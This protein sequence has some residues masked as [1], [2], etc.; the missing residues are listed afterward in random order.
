MN[1]A[2]SSRRALLASAVVA[3]LLGAAWTFLARSGHAPSTAAFYNVVRIAEA[4]SKSIPL[5]LAGLGVALA[6]RAGFWNIGAEGQMLMGALAGAAIGTRGGIFANVFCVLLGGGAAGAAWA[7]I[8]AWLRYRR[9]APEI[10]STIML[11]YLAVQLVAFA[12]LGPLQERARSQP[13]SDVLPP[14]AQLPVLIPNTTFHAGAF[15]AVVCAAALWHL[16][17]RTERGFLMRASG[18]GEAAARLHGIAV[19]RE[20]VLAVA[21]SGALCGLA[22][23]CDLAGA[24]RQLSQSGSG[25]GYT[26]IAVALLA[27]SHPAGVLP[28]ALLFGALSAGGG[29][30]E[31]SYN[32]PAVIVSVVTGLVIFAVAVSARRRSL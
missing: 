17:F 24:T 32:I 30:M 31:R 28:A 13:Q 26:A 4:L 20:R 2:F 3:A 11:N 8:A 1:T 29:V 18:E 10:I 21:L 15:I 22:G 25:T 12:V 14:A 6:F 16:L 9:G 5:A 27:G 23:A 19:E 7:A